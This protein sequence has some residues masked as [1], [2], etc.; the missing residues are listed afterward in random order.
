MIPEFQHDDVVAAIR[1]FAD[2]LKQIVGVVGDG[3][4]TDYFNPAWTAYT[5]LEL[6]QSLGLGW[7]LA[8]HPAEL[9]LVESR[10]AAHAAHGLPYAISYRLRSADD[11]YKIFSGVMFPLRD[12]SGAITRWIGLVDEADIAERA[13][14]RFKILADAMPLLVWATDRDD[15]LT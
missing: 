6:E 15:R 8:L 13:N 12:G 3:M 5:G 4:R 14:D 11:E 9:P 1:E 10:F 7:Q 2:G